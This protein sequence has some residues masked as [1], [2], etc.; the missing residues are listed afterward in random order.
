MVF[1]IDTI[2]FCILHIIKRCKILGFKHLQTCLWQFNLKLGYQLKLYLTFFWFTKA[3]L[4]LYIGWYT[5]VPCCSKSYFYARHQDRV[6]KNSG[7]PIFSPE[8][9]IRKLV[10][11]PRK[12]RIVKFK[13]ENWTNCTYVLKPRKPKKQLFDIWVLI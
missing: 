12:V 9:D 11:G 8:I 4:P 7:M 10:K 1:T 3:I 5:F 6:K 13:A 2:N